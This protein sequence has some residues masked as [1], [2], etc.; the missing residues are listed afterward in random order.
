MFTDH[1]SV[2]FDGEEKYGTLTGGIC[3]I[4]SSYL[5]IAAI[6]I[7]LAIVIISLEEYQLSQSKI[8]F[9]EKGM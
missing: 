8:F 3:T 9:D 2:L 1:I 4:L 5:V 6:F 7:N